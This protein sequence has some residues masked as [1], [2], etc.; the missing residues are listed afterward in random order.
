MNIKLH[1]EE[2]LNALSV[3]INTVFAN[4]KK[5]LAFAGK[6]SN[7]EQKQEILSQAKTLEL[8]LQD[9]RKD[10]EFY[11]TVIE[12]A[13]KEGYRTESLQVKSSLDYL[14]LKIKLDATS[15]KEAQLAKIVSFLCKNEHTTVLDGILK[16]ARQEMENLFK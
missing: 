8:K 6:I 9:L 7:F 5:A 2:K 15:D 11:K 14:D 4:W 16:N 3:E 12:L 1:A 10:F 13:E